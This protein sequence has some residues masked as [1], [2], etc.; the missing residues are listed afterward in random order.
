MVPLMFRGCRDGRLLGRFLEGSGLFVGLRRNRGPR[1]S[2]VCDEEVRGRSGTGRGFFQVRVFGQECDEMRR[3]Q[4]R[5][6][7]CLWSFPQ[8]CTLLSSGCTAPLAPLA[9]GCSQFLWESPLC[10]CG[11][12]G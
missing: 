2:P 8:F 11:R 7:I 3:S 5:A 12:A 9:P 6:T 4:D 1:W 10:C